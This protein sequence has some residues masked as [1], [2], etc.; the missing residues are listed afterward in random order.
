MRGTHL[1]NQVLI[2]P[3]DEAFRSLGGATTREYYINTGGVV[4]A[5][6]LLVQQ[7]HIRLAV[8]AELS[9][10]RIGHDLRKATAL[11]VDELWIVVPT[12]RLVRGV[13][14]KVATLPLPP[15]W[16]DVFVLTQG[17][18]LSRVTQCLSL[19]AGA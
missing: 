6:D 9:V 17:Q 15:P 7:D 18:A 3:L 16:L 14:R 12:V 1:H 19:I 5:V 10:K 2:G 8:E 4:G 11:R 13:R